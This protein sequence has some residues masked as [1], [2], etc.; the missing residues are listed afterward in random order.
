MT[1]SWSHGMQD[2]YQPS[3]WGKGGEGRGG[4]GLKG[5]AQQIQGSPEGRHAPCGVLVCVL[6]CATTP[7]GTP[8]CHK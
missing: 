2:M 1:E 4:G 6:H 7:L 8:P 3:E 5:P